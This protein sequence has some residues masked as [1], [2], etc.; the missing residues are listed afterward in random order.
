MTLIIV[1]ARSTSFFPSLSKKYLQHGFSPSRHCQYSRFPYSVHVAASPNENSPCP[2]HI[3]TFHSLLLFVPTGVSASAPTLPSYHSFF[4]N[5][6]IIYKLLHFK[7]SLELYRILLFRL[8]NCRCS[9]L[10]QVKSGATGFAM[11]QRT[12]YSAL[13]VSPQLHLQSSTIAS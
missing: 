2:S 1:S 7:K 5:Q 4:P 9:Y 3:V 13:R 10:G 11:C 8:Y 6:S 12:R